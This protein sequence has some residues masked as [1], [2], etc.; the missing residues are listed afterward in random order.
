MLYRRAAGIF[1]ALL[2]IPQLLGSS[3][4]ACPRHDENHT[5]PV[6]S[7]EPMEGHEHHD[8]TSGQ[9]TAPVEGHPI[10]D[11]CPAMS[12]CSSG[13][14]I[15]AADSNAAARSWHDDAP[16]DIATFSP[17]RVESPDPPPPKA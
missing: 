13:A 4:L 7:T 2:L 10:P 6:V 3:E 14:A 15:Q 1:A 9:N 8:E 5:P 16:V 12:T 11:C 17:S